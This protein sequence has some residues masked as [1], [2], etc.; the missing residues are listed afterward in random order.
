VFQIPFVE[1]STT[2]PPTTLQ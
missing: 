2:V 1:F